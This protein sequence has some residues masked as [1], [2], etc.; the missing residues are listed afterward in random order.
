M[1]LNAD[2]SWAVS[3]RYPIIF[4]PD[5]DAMLNGNFGLRTNLVVPALDART[6]VTKGSSWFI[7]NPVVRSRFLHVPSLLHCVVFF[8]TAMSLK[9]RKRFILGMY[10]NLSTSCLQ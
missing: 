8:A 6:A 10:P 3:P 1:L 4:A 9:Q 2:V 5:C 7:R